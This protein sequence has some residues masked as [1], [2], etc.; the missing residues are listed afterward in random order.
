V[1]HLF[2]PPAYR[3]RM[4]AERSVLKD[5]LLSVLV[6]RSVRRAA[7]VTAGSATTAGWLHARCGVD[8]TVV[9]PGLEEAFFEPGDIAARRDPYLFHVAG[10]DPRDRTQLVL[11]AV[12]LLGG[13]SPQ[14]VIAGSPDSRRI[15]I[16]EEAA[17]LGIAEK[18]ELLGW[19]SDE[20][21]RALYRG[22]LALVHVP[23]YEAYGGLPALE[24][25]ALGTPVIAFR[26]PGVSE[27]LEGAAL[28]LDP[29][30]PQALAAAVKRLVMEA[31]LR[32]SLVAAGRSRVE[33][34]RWERSALQLTEVFH[35]V[36]GLPA[37][38]R[39]ASVR[40]RTDA[41]A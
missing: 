38:S 16:G 27:A 20:E 35:G 10:A 18:V 13:D 34:L 19:V 12:A 4:R 23:R 40:S 32:S 37:P 6:P 22:A 31:E 14:L 30:E 7:A 11:A 21:L 39:I 1:L 8:A 5:A 9:L 33:P 26:A 29:A 2:E 17:K 3:L 28:L 25:M 41:S 36:L 24:A 15:R